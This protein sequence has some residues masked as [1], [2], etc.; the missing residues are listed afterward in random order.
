MRRLMSGVVLLSVLVAPLVM[1]A[2]CGKKQPPVVQPPAP[3]PPPTPVAPAPPPPP[4]PPP[5]APAPP[6]APKPPTEQE[7]F[8]RL[9]LADLIAQ[10]PLDDVFFD[11][12]KSDLSDAARASLQKDADYLKKWSSVRITVEGHADKRGTAEYN[13]ALGER[14]AN[15][16]RDY[17]GSLGVDLAHVAMVSKGEESPVCT[18][19]TEACFAQNRRGHMVITAK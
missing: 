13:L 6:P 11:Y 14:R 19:E 10:K 1:T 17:L 9:S 18:E 3:P 2:A 15:A 7:L 8:D 5:P 4:P 16:A 12:D